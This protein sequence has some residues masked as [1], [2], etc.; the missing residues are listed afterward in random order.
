MPSQ[1]FI[2]GVDRTSDLVRE[3]VAIQE[4]SSYKNS[5]MSFR[6]RALAALP[7]ETDVIEF[8][9]DDTLKFSGMVADLENDSDLPELSSNINS[10]DWYDALLAQMVRTSYVGKTL[11]Y[12]VQDI[13]R[14]RVLEAD[15]KCMLQFEEGTGTTAEDSTVYDNYGTLV[16]AGVTWDTANYA[17]DM[18]GAASSYLNILDGADIDF[19]SNFS[20]CVE[21]NVDVLNQ[22]ILQKEG[23]A[24]RP[25]KIRI[26]SSGYVIFT[27]TDSGGTEYTLT[28]TTGQAITVG[29]AR[30]IVCTFDPSSGNGK[31]YVDGVLV[32]TGTLTTSTL[33][34]S[35][36]DLV[37]GASS[38]TSYDGKL[39]RLSMYSRTLSAIEARRWH[40]DFLEVK[41]P[42]RLIANHSLTLPSEVFAYMWAADCFTQMAAEVSLAW[43]I[44]HQMFV[45]FFDLGGGTPIMTID[46]EDGLS[47]IAGTMK[48]KK[49]R[50]QVRNVIFVRGGL[51]AGNWQQDVLKAN[52]SDTVFALPYKY[53]G[54]EM[55]TD[56][57]SLCG[58][59]RSWWK[60]NVASGNITDDKGNNTLDSLANLTYAQ[61]GQIGDAID[62]NGTTS[63][64][65]KAAGSHPTGNAEHS[66]FVWIK[67][68]VHD[69][70]ERYVIGMGDFAGNRSTL[71]LIVS[72][73]IYYLRHRFSGTDI[74][75]V[76]VGDLSGA[77]HVV[78]MSY[79]P[80]ASDGPTVRL[81]LD[82][83]LKSETVVTAANITSGV[84]ELG[85]NNASNVFDGDIDECGILNYTASTQEHLAIYK[86]G[87]VSAITGYLLRTG[88]EFVDDI[89]NFDALYNYQEKNYKF[90]TAPTN[91]II[92]YPTGQPQIPVQAVRSNSQSIATYGRREMEINDQTMDNI[93]AARARASGE[94][95]LRKL[96]PVTIS[97][98]TLR[99][100]ITPGVVVSVLLPSY[101]L[102]TGDYFVQ[103]VGTSYFLPEASGDIQHLYRVEA[104]NVLSKDWID[105]LR[106][107]FMQ[108][109]RPIDP[110][111]IETVGDLIDYSEDIDVSDV[112]AIATPIAHDE[113]VDVTDDHALVEV[114]SGGYK[115]SNDAGTT[116]DK[117]R[118]SLGDWG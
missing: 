37:V 74:T 62:F 93:G 70:T 34:N 11:G 91:N 17:I 38:G 5:S 107:A 100:G 65:R 75:D 77:W 60:M 43:R 29:T 80:D 22:I 47:I 36:G 90:A 1:L 99:A 39:Y 69:T 59:I 104:V 73:G 63:K 88:I 2:N 71:S 118:W 53:E 16:G 92:F 49:D 52:G 48:V 94:L 98:D 85:G 61:T 28:Q 116:T 15:L 3:S 87:N 35:S 81:Y 6:L 67:P 96:P 115:W 110:K 13:V 114:T 40:L 83:D 45:K 30:S 21:V 102:D 112:H 105:F 14:T 41:A 101:G 84:V 8:Y 26:D 42:L 23:G 89:V 72:G 79:D 54:F 19:T 27:V 78:G 18:T 109:R 20:A 4:D 68:D 82:G 55:F 32:K 24:N 12:I 44:D 106:D 108:K 33:L 7:T 111:E 58:D 64:A 95:A 51:Y 117:L 57:I 86:L 66:M 25:Y 10:L 31:I 50:T 9:D 103:S 56:T 97:F 46:E 113:D 76:V